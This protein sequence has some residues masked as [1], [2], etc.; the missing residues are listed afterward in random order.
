MSRYNGT[1]LRAIQSTLPCQNFPNFQV[2]RESKIV[3]HLYQGISP[4][5]FDNFP[6]VIDVALYCH[7]GADGKTDTENLAKRRLRQ[8]KVVTGLEIAV[9]CPI[10][11]VYAFEVYCIA[12][13]SRQKPE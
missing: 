10:K 11:G 12:H 13:R 2:V 5:L 1:K 7:G 3:A 9:E 6:R 4:S 8:R